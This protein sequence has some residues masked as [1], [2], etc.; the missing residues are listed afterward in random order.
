MKID[1]GSHLKAPKYRTLLYSI[2]LFAFRLWKKTFRHIL[3]TYIRWLFHEICKLSKLIRK[4]ITIFLQ[5]IEGFNHLHFCPLEKRHSFNLLSFHPFFLL[6]IQTWLIKI[7][8]SILIFYIYFYI[9]NTYIIH[10]TYIR[11]IFF[12][13]FIS[14][15]LIKQ[16]NNLFYLYECIIK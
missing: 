2:L 7:N 3:Q 15:D 1:F 12:K 5:R 13:T 4:Q 8:N 6:L 11:H 10:F 16:M 9:Y 14:Y